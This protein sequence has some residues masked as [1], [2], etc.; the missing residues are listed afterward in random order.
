VEQTNLLG[1][2]YAAPGIVPH[3]FFQKRIILATPS[4]GEK[5]FVVTKDQNTWLFETELHTS[6]PPTFLNDRK[7]IIFCP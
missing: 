5:K 2:N 6:A 7:D 3:K 4:S 1:P